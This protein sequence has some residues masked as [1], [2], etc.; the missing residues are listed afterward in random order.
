MKDGEL[1]QYGS[2]LF[3][4]L[5]AVLFAVGVMTLNHLISRRNPTKEKQLSYECGENP[6]GTGWLRFNIRFYIIALIFVLFDADMALIYPPTV[7]FRSLATNTTDW[8]PA[9]IVFGELFFF[10]GVLGLGLIYVWNKG[11][12]GWVRSFQP[13]TDHGMRAWRTVPADVRTPAKTE[14]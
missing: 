8:R 10:V 11:D 6:I 13:S 4:L 3:L 14:V 2:T 9:L 5:V 7:I 1:L 12:L